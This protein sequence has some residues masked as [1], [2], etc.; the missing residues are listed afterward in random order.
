MI[1]W[2]EY[3]KDN[4]KMTRLWKRSNSASNFSFCAVWKQYRSKGAAFKNYKKDIYLLIEMVLKMGKL[5]YTNS[6]F[7]FV[8]LMD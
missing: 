5:V 3:G 8:L 2:S 1:Q 4:K 7:Y 6:G